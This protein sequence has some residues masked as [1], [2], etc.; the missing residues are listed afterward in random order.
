MLPGADGT[1]LTICKPFSNLDFF[2]PLVDRMT[3]ADPSS[4][5]DAKAALERWQG[6][7]ESISAVHREWRPRAHEELPLETFVLDMSSLRQFFTFCV[8][9]FVKRVRP[10]ASS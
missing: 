1:Q 2:K 3:Q 6:I 8:R 7:R 5:P 4:R 9:S 10:K